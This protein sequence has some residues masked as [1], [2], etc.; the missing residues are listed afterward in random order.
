[1]NGNGMRCARRVT[2]NETDIAGK[3]DAT[4]VTDLDGTGQTECF[5]LA[6]RNN[7]LS[8][9][10]IDAGVIRSSLS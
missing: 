6:C 8:R 4:D 9:V 7:M 10:F 3:A 1:M 2:E 5:H